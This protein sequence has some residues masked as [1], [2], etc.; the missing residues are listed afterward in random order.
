MKELFTMALIIASIVLCLVG[1]IKL[2]FKT[3]KEKHPQGYK[4]TFTGIC[5]FLCFG[6]SVIG[7]LFFLSKDLISYEFVTLVCAVMS[8]VTGTYSS[9]EGLGAK[10]LVKKIIESLKKLKEVTKDE[11]IIK[12]INKIEDIDKAITLLV[13]KRNHSNEV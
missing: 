3:F 1:L 2:P 9:Y 13:E 10:A 4:S 11:K 12:H 8:G 5:I 6:L 7:E